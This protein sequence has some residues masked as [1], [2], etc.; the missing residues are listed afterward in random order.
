[1]TYLVINREAVAK[2]LEAICNKPGIDCTDLMTSFTGSFHVL[3]C[4][5]MMREKCIF[6]I[7]WYIDLHGLSLIIGQ[8]C[9]LNS[10]NSDVFLEHEPQ[11]TA[12]KNMIHIAQSKSLW[13]PCRLRWFSQ[14]DQKMK[15]QN[16]VEAMK[17]DLPRMNFFTAIHYIHKM[18]SGCFCTVTFYWIRY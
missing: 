11:S 3:A 14:F 17:V 18:F 2:L 13:I 1:M 5:L 10:S 7:I 4:L 9:C 6:P 12:T 16:S 8:N 15:N